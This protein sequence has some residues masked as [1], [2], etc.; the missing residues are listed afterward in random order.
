MPDV[1]DEMSLGRMVKLLVG[2][3]DQDGMELPFRNQEPWHLLFYT[4]KKEQMAE[5]KPEFLDELVF[6]WDGPSPNCEELSEYLT[7]LHITGNVSGLNPR[8]DVIAVN[9]DRAARWVNDLEQLNADAKSYIAHAVGL[10]R[11]EF[12]V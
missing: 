10:A 7:G 5:G 11:E 12:A 6:A 1:R 8:F 2:R 9:K 3:L 4:L